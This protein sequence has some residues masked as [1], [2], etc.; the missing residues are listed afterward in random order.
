MSKWHSFYLHWATNRTM[1]KPSCV[2]AEESKQRELLVT[3]H[4]HHSRIFFPYITKLLSVSGSTRVR[5]PKSRLWLSTYTLFQ[6]Q[7]VELFLLLWE[8]LNIV[9]IYFSEQQRVSS[10]QW[11]ANIISFPEIHTRAGLATN[12]F[13]FILIFV[14]FRNK[15]GLKYYHW[16]TPLVLDHVYKK[17]LLWHFVFGGNVM[18][19]IL[20]CARLL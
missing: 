12:T 1:I 4:L 16:P 3:R 10:W 2:M 18:H 19:R 6:K 11:E 5:S 8:F 20:S 9:L 7:N 13:S 15:P 17:K 14:V